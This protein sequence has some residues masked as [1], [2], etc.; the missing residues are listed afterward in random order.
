VMI[1]VSLM[2][3]PF[4]E[5]ALGTKIFVAPPDTMTL[6]LPLASQVSSSVTTSVYTVVETGL[7]TGSLMVASFSPVDGCHLYVTILPVTETFI[8]VLDPAAMVTSG[9][10]VRIG[11]GFTTM[12]ICADVPQ[13]PGV[14]VN[15]YTVR[16]VVAVLIEEGLQLPLI[17]SFDVSGSAGV[18]AFWQ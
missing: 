13:V 2:P 9:P 16:P 18:V 14:G 1:Q 12:A 17:P 7:A 15:V 3:S 4:G 8:V 5:K 11:S 10:M 6:M